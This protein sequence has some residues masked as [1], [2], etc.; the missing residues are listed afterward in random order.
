MHVFRAQSTAVQVVVGELLRGV[1]SREEVVLT[2]QNGFVTRARPDFYY[3]LDVLSAH[4]FGYG[5]TSR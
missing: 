2:P 3:S 1:G 4:V 5:M